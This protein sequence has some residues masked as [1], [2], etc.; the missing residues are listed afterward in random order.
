MKNIINYLLI[1][2]MFNLIIQKSVPIVNL[3]N[4]DL[5]SINMC[6]M[7]AENSKFNSSKKL[8]SVIR[9]G[10]YANGKQYQI[11]VAQ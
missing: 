1:V 2:K 4:R 10:S 9:C 5:R 11:K 3:N 8:G 6:I 7:A